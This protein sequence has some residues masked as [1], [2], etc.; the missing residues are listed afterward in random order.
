VGVA[1]RRNYSPDFWH[2][3]G[4]W[5]LIPS[6]QLRQSAQKRDDGGM[7]LGICVRDIGGSELVE[8]GRFAEQHGYA[9]VFVPDTSNGGMRDKGGRLNGRNAFVALAAMFASTTTV[10]GALGVAAAIAHRPDS[11]ALTA[12]S[13]AE[14]SSDRFSL[15]IGVSHRELATG[16][17]VS[18]PESPIAYMR[19]WLSDMRA[20]SQDGTSF[21][22]G[23]PVLLGSL[24]PRMTELGATGADGVVL[25]WLTPEHTAETVRAVRAAEPSPSSCK[26]ILYVRVMPDEAARADAISYDA[27]ANYHRNFVAQGLNDVDA[28]VAGTTLRLGDLNHARARIDEY[29][30][31]G[32]DLLCVYPHALDPADR[33]RVL[34]AITE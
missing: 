15:G 7:D 23:W 34:A 28:I 1:K 17:G 21:G 9:D 25:N 2:D 33:L 16:L 32:L 27:L 8:L 26:T 6:Y 20:A 22:G 30:A 24:G 5:W 18:F 12:S 31:S 11:L 29:R 13:L 19:S 14:L 4:R 3:R 10:R